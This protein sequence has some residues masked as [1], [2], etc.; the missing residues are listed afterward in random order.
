VVWA[1]W[2]YL[3]LLVGAEVQAYIEER[4]LRSLTTPPTP[5]PRDNPAVL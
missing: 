4:R 3:I 5:E 1:Y 2:S